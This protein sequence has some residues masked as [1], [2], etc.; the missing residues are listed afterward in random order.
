M[1]FAV[2]FSSFMMLPEGSAKV[3]CHGCPLALPF[4]NALSADQYPSCGQVFKAETEF[5]QS[6][7][8]GSTF[9]KTYEV[10]FGAIHQ[11]ARLGA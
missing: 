9:P 6:S 7:R 11:S 2:L 1:K 8:M 3:L 10:K 5:R 4:R